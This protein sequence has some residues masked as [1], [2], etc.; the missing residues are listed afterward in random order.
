VGLVFVGFSMDFPFGGEGLMLPSG[1]VR[2]FA[3]ELV[4]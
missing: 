3:T 4:G 1:P 2:L